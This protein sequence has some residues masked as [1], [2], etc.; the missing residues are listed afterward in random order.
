MELLLAA[1]ILFLFLRAT[2]QQRLACQPVRVRSG[3]R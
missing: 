2:R 3:R 1:L